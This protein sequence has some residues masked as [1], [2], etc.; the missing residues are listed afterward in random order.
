MKRI[1]LSTLAFSLLAN[2]AQA[3][4][5]SPATTVARAT[6]LGSG[7]QSE[8]FDKTVRAQDNFY[9]HAQGAWLSANEIPADKS[10][11]GTFMKAREDVQQQL[12]SIV[13]GAAKDSKQLAG[14]DLQ[15]IGDLYNSFMDEK[16]LNAQGIAALKNELTQIAA[17]QNKK[18][19]PALIARFHEIGVNTPLRVGVGQDSKNSSQYAVDVSQGGLGLPNR[20][21]Y[22]KQDDQ[23]MA[24]IRARYKV[25]IEKMLTLA[26]EKNVA[27]QADN[28]IALETELA[29]VQWTAVENRNPVKTYN[30]L[31]VG[32]LNKM[33]PAFDWAAYL[34]AA[35]MRQKVS[36]LI[37]Q[38]PSFVKGFGDNLHAI[39][40][41][42]WKSYFNWHLISAYSPYLSSEFINED[43]AFKG[44]AIAGIKENRS[45]DKRGVA[46]VDQ[47][48]GEA[49]GKIYVEKHFSPEVKQRTEKMVGYFL[50]A[51]RQS[52]DTLDWM[53]PETKKQAQIKLSKI[54]V[55]IGYPKQWR[56]Y[57]SLTIKSDDLAGNLMRVRKANHDREI[58]KLGK[59]IDREEW[60]MTPQTVNAYYSPEMNEI[61]FP[62]ARLQS[63][64]FDVNAEDAFNYGSL[65][66][67][68]G[69]E[70][71]HAFDDQGS[72]YDGDGNLRNWWTAEDQE[73]FKA[74]T[75]TLVEQY[76]AYSPV[77]GHF[78]NGELTLGENIA[79]NAGIV[80]ALR[81]YKLSLQGKPA[82]VIDGWTAEQRLFMGLAQ[83]RRG[84]S[85]EQRAITLIKVDPHSPGE[86]RVNGSLVNH[87]DF[88][89]SFDVKPGDKMY[90]TPEKR[91]SIW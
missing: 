22:L 67:S 52:I 39:P 34:K 37:V 79:D 14:S 82:P 86:F 60:H 15:K 89:S 27:T 58:A 6:S 63:P 70:I 74:K 84:K 56:D 83:A 45:R 69:H 85:R 59:P 54:S 40:L 81:A 38:Q 28:I 48:L 26:G 36:D 35:H 49:V 55:K 8:N 73:K 33:T 62:A 20:D 25:H 64:L 30:K 41:E 65:G 31:S 5:T 42:N 7:I 24:D 9:R 32:E 80:M 16:K 51:F 75:K 87:P 77:A 13:E 3:A 47:M 91:V 46:L 23:K 53:S 10:D 18:A 11:W 76:N 78:L 68:I 72:Q 43:F 2:A 66:I 50:E 12:R 88:Y 19:I 29:K 44:A 71:S 61:V 90:L 1:L 21:Y 4:E 17:I 57:S